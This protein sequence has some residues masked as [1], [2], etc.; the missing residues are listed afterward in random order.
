MAAVIEYAN[1]VMTDMAELVPIGAIGG[2]HMTGCIARCS[3]RSSTWMRSANAPRSRSGFGTAS[4]VIILM[5]AISVGERRGG[6]GRGRE[7]STRYVIVICLD[8]DMG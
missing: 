4:R 8:C 5:G 3:A 2:K 6:S 7:D 1:T